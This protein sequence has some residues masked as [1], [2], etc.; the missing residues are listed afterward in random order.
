MPPFDDAAVIAGQG[1]IGLEL[2]EEAPDAEVVVVPVGGGGL[3]AGVGAALTL[4]NV[5]VRVGPG[6]QLAGP[7]PRV[8]VIGVEAAGAPT[9]TN[10]LAAGAAGDPRPGG[11][12]WRTES[13]WPPAAS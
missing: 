6:G 5:P 8:R 4:S 2:A 13:P 11:A 10:A 12:P 9:L 7:R 3:L 1:T